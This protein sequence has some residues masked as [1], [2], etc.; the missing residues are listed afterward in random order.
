MSWHWI[1]YIICGV[2]GLSVLTGFFRGFLKELIALCVWFLAIWLAFTYSADLDPWVR[3][4][5]HDSTA[6]RAVCFVMILLATIIVGGLFN[7][8]LSFILRRSGLSGTDRLLGL[9]FGF[10]R[11]IFIVGLMMLIVK[12]SGFPY[13]S[14]TVQSQFYSRFDPLVSWLATFTPSLIDQVKNLDK[15]HSNL[16]QQLQTLEPSDD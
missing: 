1:D 10:V 2:I 6:R 11:G 13:Q 9:G 14:Y 5:I 7:A 8:I 4:Y 12:L 16:S 3:P 15:E